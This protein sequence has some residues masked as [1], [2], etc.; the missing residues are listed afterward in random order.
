MQEA[1]YKQRIEL[2]D[3][4]NDK[5]YLA[6]TIA[7]AP[8]YFEMYVFKSAEIWIRD[9]VN[10]Q[11]DLPTEA[12]WPSFVKDVETVRVDKPERQSELLA[13]VRNAEPHL[14]LAWAEDKRRGEVPKTS[15]ED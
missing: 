1:V 15:E 11:Y 9:S 5:P 6:A 3:V 13:L 4:V 14:L 10:R 8:L 7:L 12:E 2:Q